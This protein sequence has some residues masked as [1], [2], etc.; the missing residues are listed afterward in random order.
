MPIAE[1][2]GVMIGQ[3]FIIISDTSPLLETKSQCTE[4]LITVTPLSRVLPGSLR[5]PQLVKKFPTYYW[6]CY[7]IQKCLPPVHILSLSNS[8][9]AYTSH[10][11]KTVLISSSHLCLCLPSGL[12]R[13][14]FPTKILFWKFVGNRL[15]LTQSW[16]LV[17]YL[18]LIF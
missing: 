5:S 14:G 15:V 2:M 11:W 9:H 4:A 13:L 3:N 12:F 1:L 7:H 6:T 18:S 8:I 16:G 17:S 10:L